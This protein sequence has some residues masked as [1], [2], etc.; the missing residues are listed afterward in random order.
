MSPKNIVFEGL[1]TEDYLV[2]PSV[3]VVWRPGGIELASGTTVHFVPTDREPAPGQKVK[4]EIPLNPFFKVN[5]GSFR[6]GGGAANS[7]RAAAQVL[8][9]MGLDSEYRV[10]LLDTGS[11]PASA[12]AS[13]ARDGIELHSLGRCPTPRSLI[14]KHELDRVIVSELTAPRCGSL[15]DPQ[16]ATVA[17][18]VAGASAV[19]S[20]SRDPAVSIEVARCCNGAR[21]HVGATSTVPPEHTMREAS[22]AHT[23]VLNFD[24]LD[25]LGVGA[26]LESSQTTEADPEAPQIAAQT[27]RALRAKRLA[28]SQRAIVTL[29]RRGVVAADWETEQIHCIQIRLTDDTKGVPT[30]AGTGDFFLG[31]FAVLLEAWA[32]GSLL[33]DAFLACVIRAMHAVAD[34]IGLKRDFYHL[35]TRTISARPLLSFVLPR[36]ASS[37]A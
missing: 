22:V 28:G 17:Q 12:T 16:A 14:I 13:F 10:R 32:P 3:P 18:A 7:A 20:S 27:L 1:V 26:G 23:L 37:A 4:A 35:E 8:R 11:L 31:R 6:H 25:R 30:P 33:R 24:E 15:T 19:V 29:G 34:S 2:S 9:G 5:G 36:S 21:R